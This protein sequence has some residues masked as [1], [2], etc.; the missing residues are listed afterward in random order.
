MTTGKPSDRR[1][2]DVGPVKRWARNDRALFL[3]PEVGAWAVVEGVGDDILQRCDGCHS[4]DEV[5]RELG[6]RYG[7]SPDT[8]AQDV[9]RYL[10]QLHECGFFRRNDN[11]PA[12][13]RGGLEGLALHVTSRCTLSCRHCYAS[14]AATPGNDPPL[15]LLVSATEQ[16]RELGARVFKLTGGDP[17]CRPEALEALAEPTRGCEVTVLTNGCAPAPELLEVVRHRGWRLQ[18]SIDGATEATHDWYRGPGAFAG[19]TSNLDE[20]AAEGEIESVTLSVCVSRVNRHEVE[21]IVQRSLEWGVGHVHLARV[22][23]HGMA[24]EWWES[25]DQTPAEWVETY[26]ELARIWRAYRERV[27]LTGFMA[28]YLLGC[29]GRPETRGCRPGRHVMM[30]LDGGIYPCIM[31]GV[32]ETRLGRLPEDTLAACLTSESLAALRETCEGRLSD[33]T[34]CGACDWRVVCR[35]ACPGWSLVQDGTLCATDELCELRRELLPEL[36]LDFS[37]QAQ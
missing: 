10:T 22:S 36:I 23:R 26:R 18:V 8:V 31:M 32:P 1:L 2:P 3:R 16:A 25:L 27:N 7:V 35:G 9:D 24:S 33:E 28:D 11:P 13:I 37:E 12:E 30:D 19:L 15:S 34:V 5:A 14:P 17:L 6:A 21:A 4:M 20:L 29:V